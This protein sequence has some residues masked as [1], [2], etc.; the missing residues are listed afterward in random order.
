MTP[1]PR[2]SGAGLGW[3][4]EGA[5]SHL[6]LLLP[7]DQFPGQLKLRSWMNHWAS[8]HEPTA[9]LSSDLRSTAP[10]RGSAILCLAAMNR[11]QCSMTCRAVSLARPHWQTGDGKSGTRALFRNAARPMHPVRICVITT[12]S[13]LCSPEWSF[14]ELPCGWLTPIN[15]HSS[16]FP[17]HRCL[18]V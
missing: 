18:H 9:Q 3:W 8:H 2:G 17:S 15:P 4:R 1:A 12:L 6:E 11:L 13:A 14:S 16:F 7:V 10:D 5:L